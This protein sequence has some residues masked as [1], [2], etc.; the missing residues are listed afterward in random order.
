MGNLMPHAICASHVVFY[1]RFQP[2]GNSVQIKETLLTKEGDAWHF[3]MSS[4]EKAQCQM[5]RNK[6]Q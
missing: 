4:A 1:D 5:G 3:T 2:L 6:I